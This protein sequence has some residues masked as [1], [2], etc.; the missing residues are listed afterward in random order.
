MVGRGKAQKVIG[1]HL[2][3]I[4]IQR[5]YRNRSIFQKNLRRARMIGRHAIIVQVQKH[6][7]KT[8]QSLYTVALLSRSIGS[9]CGP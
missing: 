3:A 5:S 1:L 7:S 2:A 4:S 6:D 8:I 9:N